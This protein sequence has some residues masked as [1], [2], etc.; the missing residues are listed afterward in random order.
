[1]KPLSTWTR[2]WASRTPRVLHI[3][4]HVPL[5]SRSAIAAMR[6]PAEPLAEPCTAAPEAGKASAEDA[7]PR[8]PAE[9]LWSAWVPH[10]AGPCPIP[11]AKARE[12]QTRCSEGLPAA[13]NGSDAACLLGWDAAQSY[14]VF[15]TIY[16]QI[17]A[18]RL[19][20][21]AG[22]KPHD[23]K[24]HL[25]YTEPLEFVLADGSIANDGFRHW[26]NGKYRPHL[27]IIGYRQ[28]G[29]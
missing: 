22:F 17:T 10:E 18:Y 24:S 5:F 3:K 20:L 14:Q 21:P 25:P 28:V 8:E 6:V 19:L 15:G 27:R 7:K 13:P 29:R 26:A 12:F 1:M 2:I 23:G 4:P 9:R 16:K 11:N